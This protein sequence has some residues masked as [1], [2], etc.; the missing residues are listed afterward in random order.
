MRRLCLLLGLSCLALIWLGPLLSVWRNSFASHMLAHMGVVAV[1]A[2][3]IAIGI[4]AHPWRSM[5]RPGVAI[6]ASLIE[7]VIVWGWHAPYLRELAQTYLW[8][9]VLEQASFLGVGL[10]LWFSSIATA[11]G[12]SSGS[13]AAGV[14]GLLLTSIHMTLLG[15]LLALSSR[16]LYGLG[17]VTCLGLRL[18]AQQDQTLGGVMMLLIGGAVY[19]T[20][21][22]VL[23]ARL[24][25]GENASRRAV[26]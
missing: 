21:G 11:G 5:N 23:L 24:L 1:G 7:L 4:A 3:L 19:L 8:V 2:P 26:G 25:S 15:A 20:G 16:P 12:P 6:V 17:E 10:L 9:T 13:R 22:L 14:F 18:D